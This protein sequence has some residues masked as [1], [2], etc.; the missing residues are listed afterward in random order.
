M[1]EILEARKDQVHEK[2]ASRSTWPA[3][4]RA[5]PA[6]S[7][8]GLASSAA[9]GW[10]CTRSPT[11][12]TWCTGPIGCAA[13][14]WDIRGSLSSGPELHRLSFSTDLQERD[15]IFGGEKKL[16]KALIELIDH[17]QPKA[18]F[19]YSTCIVGVI[20]DDVEAV[21]RRVA[22]EKG[23]PVLPVHS[24][25]LK[26]TKK[27]G[28]RAACDALM[29]AGRH[30]PDRGHQPA[31]HQHPGR[32]QPGRRNVDD[33]RLLR[34]DGRRGGGH[35]HRRRPHGRHPPR[36]RAALNVVQCSGSMIHL[37]KTMEEQY[38]IPYLRVSYFGIEDMAKSLY[39]VA[40]LL[41]RRG[42]RS[43]RAATWSAR[44]W[45]TIMPELRRYREALAGRRA[46][47]YMGGAFKAFS[48]VR[49]L[50][51][52]GMKTVVVGSQTGNKRGL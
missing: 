25:G 42:D 20:G 23:I 19:V 28:Y 34:A 12:C 40:E 16:Y 13:Y 41:R 7:A 22:A 14:T 47:V 45:R 35:D 32:F 21:C 3:N 30:R 17:Y 52:L 18:A 46:A 51:T 37:A 50:R 33:P 48:L 27:D 4:S 24:R 2:G 26:G 8:S 29:Q 6:R 44:K 5:W 1:I 43:P 11:P 36:P 9:R 38:G 49:S 10:C 15:V 39:D 31:Q